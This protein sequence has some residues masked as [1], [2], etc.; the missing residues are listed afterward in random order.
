LFLVFG[1][2]I[3]HAEGDP[4]DA[5]MESIRPEAIRADKRFLS[6]DLLEGRG[7]GSRVYDIA[8]KYMATQFEGMGLEGAGE[9]GTYFQSAPL[10]SARPKKEAK[11]SVKLGR[12]GK[13]E[14]LV[15][16]KDFIA[17]GDPSR[18]DTSVEAPSRVRGRR[19]D[20]A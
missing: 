5:A 4:A 2:G 1:T 10:R 12:G 16:R 17:G 7:A 9:N 14:T 11:T 19:S 8:A 3:T 6:D 15:F 20:R 18:A 13:V